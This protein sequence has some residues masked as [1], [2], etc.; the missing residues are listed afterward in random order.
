[1]NFQTIPPVEISRQFLEL[2]F[3]KARK[4]GKEKNLTG[5]WLQIIRKKEGLKLDI[6]TDTLNSKL[7][8]IIF[9]FPNLDDL[10]PF[11]L[12]LMKLTLDYPH[13]K[14][15]LS[16]L[17]WAKSK[18]QSLH[19]ESVSKIFKTSDREKIKLLSKE[20]YG[21]ISSILKQIDSS[22]L[23]LE[24][25]RQTMKTYPDIKNLFTVCIYGFP[26]VG[27]T[28]LL[29]KLTGT[30]ALTASYA[31]TTTSINVGYLTV[32]G[33][34]IQ[35]LDVPGTL[36]R[37]DKLNKIE[38]QAELVVQELAHL[39]I[40]V[41]D[42]SEQGGYSL[43]E[44]KRLFKKISPLNKIVYFSKIDLIENKEILKQKDLS[45]IK[46]HDLQELQEQIISEAKKWN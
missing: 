3:S 23:F 11:Y 42:I 24:K 28:T 18:I 46:H 31:F 5:N 1:M 14:K 43:E 26:N 13:L 15:S 29:N 37:K 4:K 44:Q 27:K 35:L 2:A 22:L 39:I 45:E 25:S 33:Q 17:N 6:V 19:K 10:N 16:S 12:K 32:D 41:F 34:K 36:A 20:F 8:K 40:Y 30:K 9:T 21:R 38:L 7:D